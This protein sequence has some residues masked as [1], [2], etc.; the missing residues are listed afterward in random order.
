MARQAKG[1]FDVTSI[2]QEPLDLGGDTAARH[3]RFDKRF[4]GALDASSVVHML[5]VGTGVEGSAAYVAIERISG[6]LDGRA[7][8]FMVQHSG[9]MDRGAPS[10]SVDVVPDS[11]TDTLTG[12]RGRIAIDIRDGNHFYTFDYALD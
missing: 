1:E 12:L 11:G 6:T 8:S 7:G 10:L 5:A 4:H 3:V 2:P 9:T